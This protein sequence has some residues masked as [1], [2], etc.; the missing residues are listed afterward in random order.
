MR[1]IHTS[2]AVALLVP[3]FIF[4]S[5]CSYSQT[6]QWARIAAGQGFDYGNYMT[7]DDSGNVYVSGQFEYD[8][9]FGTKTVSTAGQHDIFI[10]KYNSAG[11]LM[12]V[13]RAG[14]TDGDAGHGVGLDA[15]RNVYTAGEFEK[16]CYWSP[17]DSCTV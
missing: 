11:T 16:T 1:R 14:S 15:N 2:L 12:W 8:C 7:T 3:V 4:I 17:T 6:Y 10:S 13:K 9:N 5:F